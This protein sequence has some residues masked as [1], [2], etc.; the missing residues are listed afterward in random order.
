MSVGQH[1]MSGWKN[2]VNFYSL[3]GY[4]EREREINSKY[5]SAFEMIRY[6]R[7]TVFIQDSEIGLLKYKPQ[8]FFHYLRFPHTFPIYQAIV[9]SGPQRLEQEVSFTEET[10]SIKWWG[11]LWFQISQRF[12]EILGVASVEKLCDFNPISRG[13]ETV[14]FLFLV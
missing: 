1:L 14:P 6:C 3:H 7:L 9:L 8:E 2:F 11:S 10:V 12:N 13:S 5:S 4:R